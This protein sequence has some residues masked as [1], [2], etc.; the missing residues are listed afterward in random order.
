MVTRPP[1]GLDPNN[2]L[3]EAVLPD[4]QARFEAV[5]SAYAEKYP[6][7][8]VKAYITRSCKS[9]LKQAWK[10]IDETEE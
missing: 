10:R 9:S 2:P 8:D 7:R 6:D 5:D 1:R 4:L 3:Y